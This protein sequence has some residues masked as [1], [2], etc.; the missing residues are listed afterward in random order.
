MID[1]I[2]PAAL[3]GVEARSEA[4]T[5][6]LLPE[7]ERT[8][9][10][11]PQARRREFATGRA[12]ARDALR[13]LGLPGDAIPAGPGGEPLWPAGVVGSITHCAGFWAC[14][15]GRE[16]DCA[17]VGIDAEI[18]A[19]LPAGV[20]EVVASP[21]ERDALGEFASPT[22]ETV[23]FSA[24]EAVFKAWYPLVRA[25]LGFEDVTLRIH[26]G[27]GV[28]ADLLVAGPLIDGRP[29]SGFDGR[30][31]ARDGLVVTAIV[32]PRR[33]APGAG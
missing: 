16:R 6:S 15:V 27:G 17:S 2:L 30:W 25:W 20:L 24:K 10:T 12:C 21:G 28:H 4:L 7:E 9:G 3:V 11:A 22:F 23:L 5:A 18:D 14:A 8:V 31:V 32:V 29:L 26:P 33:P 19:P 13:R 1:E